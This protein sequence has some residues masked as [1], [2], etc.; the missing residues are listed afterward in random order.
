MN[1]GYTVPVESWTEYKRQSE[2]NINIDVILFP[3][4]RYNVTRP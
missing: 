1:G 2:L 4:C 3:G